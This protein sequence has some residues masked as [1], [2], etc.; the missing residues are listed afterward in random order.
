[1]S[2]AGARRPQEREGNWRGR[3]RPQDPRA[4]LE[5]VR[6]RA[7]R[8]VAAQVRNA[9]LGRRGGPQERMMMGP[10]GLLM[11]AGVFPLCV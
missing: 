2:G 11:G 8:S 7:R 1:M 6:K 4:A 5:G 9:A 3:L 10:P